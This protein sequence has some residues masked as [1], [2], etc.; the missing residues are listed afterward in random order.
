MAV[1]R[2]TSVGS[3]DLDDLIAD[4]ESGQISTK[5]FG[6]QLQRLE[7]E[8][9]AATQPKAGPALR[10][11]ESLESGEVRVEYDAVDGVVVP[12]S[13]RV[14]AAPDASPRWIKLHGVT[15]EA[16]RKHSGLQGEIRKLLTEVGDD[17]RAV[18]GTARWE[19]KFEVEKLESHVDSELELLRLAT[20]GTKQAD[21]A[22]ETLEALSW[23]FEHWSRVADGEI[24]PGDARGFIT[25]RKKHHKSSHRNNESDDRKAFWTARNE[26]ER[27]ER[28][29]P[30]K[31]GEETAASNLN[32]PADP[33]TDELHI[34]NNATPV[35]AGQN[36]E[37]FSHPED[38]AKLILR[39]RAGGEKSLKELRAEVKRLEEIRAAGFDVPIIY[40]FAEVRGNPAIVVEKI[41]GIFS[42]KLVK[43]DGRGDPI[44]RNP[45]L[46]QEIHRNPAAVKGLERLKEKLKDRGIDDL[47]FLITNDGRTVIIDPRGFGPPVLANQTLL[48]VILGKPSKPKPSQR[49]GSK[50][51]GGDDLDD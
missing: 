40:A 24:S 16:I 3:R 32:D 42:K 51:R 31:T 13:V 38:D 4:H 12:N 34:D 48:N 23:Q 11:D 45:T 30:A 10:F 29:E 17:P 14:V 22:Q 26:Y 33:L 28:T 37:A 15:A 27:R 6:I 49:G 25:A 39:A 44:I 21:E 5:E 1:T 41:E 9:E 18:A 43:R 47:Q 50:R 19:A 2:P 8:T 7:L 36:K 35:S 20:P 46:H